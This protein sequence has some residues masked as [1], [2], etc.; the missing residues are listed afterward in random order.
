MID[1][2]SWLRFDNKPMHGESYPLT[3]LP[4]V[5]NSYEHSTSLLE[6]GIP[7]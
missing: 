5:P 6:V 4:R 2:I 7:L 3:V 1:L